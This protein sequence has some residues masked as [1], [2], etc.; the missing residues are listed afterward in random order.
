MIMETKGFISFGLVLLLALFLLVL[1]FGFGFGFGFEG[2]NER[3]KMNKMACNRGGKDV[4]MGL[5]R[6]WFWLK[7]RNY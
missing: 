7:V 2:E 5:F 3:E 4:M 6:V 1:G